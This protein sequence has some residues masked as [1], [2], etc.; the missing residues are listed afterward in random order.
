MNEEDTI[1]SAAVA[2]SLAVQKEP[3][4]KHIERRVRLSDSYI[5][6]L[7]AASKRYSKGDSEV[8]GL[9]IY[10]E[11]SG[12]KT[13][14]YTYKPNIDKAPTKKEY[15][16]SELMWRN[17]ATERGDRSDGFSEKSTFP[18][19]GYG[20]APTDDG[21]VEIDVSYYKEKSVIDTHPNFDENKFPKV[22]EAIWKARRGDKN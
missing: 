9:R 17:S 20:D 16:S 13:F 21:S 14:F 22:A 10:V 12:T 18:G 3:I 6:K 19:Y 4:R 2:A 15:S 1:G 11:E 7:R 5:R 8:P